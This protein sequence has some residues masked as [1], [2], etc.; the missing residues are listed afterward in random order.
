MTKT[1]PTE[2]RLLDS[3]QRL[4]EMDIERL[5]S[6]T[7]DL[8]KWVT[9]A[10]LTVNG[11]P[12][13]AMLGTEELRFMLTGPGL[14][15]SFGLASSI[16]GNLFLVKGLALSGEA[17]FKE[18][19]NGRAI[20]KPQYDDVASGTESNRWALGAAVLLGVS[21]LAFLTGMFWTGMVVSAK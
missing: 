20:L 12:L 14:V 10:T 18:H 7:L 4:I 17:L 2:E 6:I 15:F 19:W 21:I 3:R 13:V 5:M 1:D 16:F 11:A 9:A 8:F